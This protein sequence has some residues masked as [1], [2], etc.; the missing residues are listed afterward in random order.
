MHGWP[1]T[2]QLAFL[3]RCSPQTRHL[4]GVSTRWTCGPRGA[5]SRRGLA[6]SPSASTPKIGTVWQ[7]TA[8]AMCIGPESMQTAARAAA[9]APASSVSRVS[10]R[11]SCS[12]ALASSHSSSPPAL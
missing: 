1:S 8:A 3:K 2:R 7:P 5:Q 11:R 4:A 12:G 10:P 6:P 9:N